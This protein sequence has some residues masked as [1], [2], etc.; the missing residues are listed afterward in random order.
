MNDKDNSQKLPR[1]TLPLFNC[2]K[3]KIPFPI[4]IIIS[5]FVEIRRRIKEG[6]PI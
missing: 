2:K 6:L 5:F 4:A 1:G 3:F